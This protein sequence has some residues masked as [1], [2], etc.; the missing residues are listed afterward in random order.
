MHMVEAPSLPGYHVLECLGKGTS[1]SVFLARS[2]VDGKL[3]ALKIF[4]RQPDSSIRFKT[5]LETLSTL[6]HPN[7][8]H[9][10]NFGNTLDSGADYLA[11]EYVDGSNFVVASKEVS[12]Q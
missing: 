2:A 8:V 3:V 6:S 11:I 1:A 10:V 4:N 7:L 5:E 12:K 9:L